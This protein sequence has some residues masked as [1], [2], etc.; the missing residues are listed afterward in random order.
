MQGVFISWDARSTWSTRT[1]Q[2][3]CIKILSMLLFLS[4]SISRCILLESVQ[5]WQKFEEGTDRK[6]SLLLL[7]FK[8]RSPDYQS[9]TLTTALWPLFFL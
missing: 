2:M 4:T 9:S 5:W 3:L 8:P 7:G 1:Y 6:I